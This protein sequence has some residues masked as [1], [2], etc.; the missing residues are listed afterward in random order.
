MLN[1]ALLF[2][3]GFGLLIIGF[4][5]M[6]MYLNLMA[7]GYSFIDYLTFIATRLECLLSLIGTCLIMLSLYKKGDKYDIHI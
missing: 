3:I 5:Y 4:T 6:I 1:R 2:L 7:M